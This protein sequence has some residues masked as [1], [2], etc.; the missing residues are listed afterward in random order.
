MTGTLPLG[1]V[2]VT[3][4]DDWRAGF[5]ERF[6]ALGREMGLSP[7]VGRQ[8]G[9]LVV[10]DPPEQSAEQIRAA[11]RLSAGSVSTGMAS[12]ARH[13]L[14]DRLAFPPDRRSYYRVAPDGWRRLLATRLGAIAGIRRVAD[15]ALS[16]AGPGADARLPEIRAF[17]RRCEQLCRDLVDGRPSS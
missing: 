12:L 3:G 13:G 10:C 9:W 17:G 1:E 11:L 5:V 16:V 15:E 6:G 7:A 8:L 4:T 14:V 2:P